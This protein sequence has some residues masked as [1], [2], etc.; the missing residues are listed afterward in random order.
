MAGLCQQDLGVAT[1]AGDP[2]SVVHRLDP[3]AKLLGFVTVTLVAISAPPRAWPAWAA[4]AV[5]LAVV[6]GLARVG[7]RVVWRRARIVL[8]LVVFVG[9][10]VP[11]VREGG[12]TYDLGP[13]S[14]TSTGLET[15]AATAAKATIGTASA[16][17]LGATTSFPA[18]LR[19]LERLRVPRLFVLIAMLTYRY[20]FVVV[21][22]V[23]RL[24]AALAARAYRPRHALQAGALGRAAG[25]LFL[26]THARGERIYLAMTARGF[27][28]TMP[29]LVALR[30]GR[31][32]A[33][34]VAGVGLPLV[35]LRVAAELAA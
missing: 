24:R 20:L 30:F 19:A 32:D 28:G 15:F 29:D 21:A 14:V 4:C 1:L 8:P 25:A 26:R 13:L 9:A 22:E 5:A 31:A 35:A 16:V 2:E 12:T 23:R 34:F 27:D 7:P 18:V 10:F 17:L 3:R 33:L 6:A 11:F